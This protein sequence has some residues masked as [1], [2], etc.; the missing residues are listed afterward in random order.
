MMAGGVPAGASAVMLNVTAVVPDG[1]PEP[2][3][4]DDDAGRAVRQPHAAARRVEAELLH[5]RR[6]HRVA[7]VLHE[8]LPARLVGGQRLARHA[9]KLRK[10]EGC[11]H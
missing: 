11:G 3:A 2:V 8:H 4:L 10:W 5:E 9:E 7:G 1:S 6:G